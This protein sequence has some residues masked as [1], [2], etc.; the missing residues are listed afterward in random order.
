MLQ[1][2]GIVDQKESTHRSLSLQASVLAIFLCILF[3]A[4]AVAIKF[5]LTGLGTFTAAAVRF[6]ISVVAI[7][8]WAR[9]THQSIWFKKGQAHQILIISVLFVA[10]ISLFYVG[11]S[12]T[13]ASRGAL[14]V[15]LVPFLVLLLSHFFTRDDRITFG[16]LLGILMGFSGILFLFLQKRDLSGELRTGDMIIL[17]ATLL[18]ACSAV[19]IKKINQNYQPFQMVFYPLLLAVPFLYICA[20]VFDNPMMNSPGGDVVAAILYQGL[21]TGS[22]GFVAW[23]V[24]LQR[25]GAVSLHTFIFIMPVIGVLLGGLMLKEPIT[26]NVLIALALIG[27]GIFVTQFKKRRLRSMIDDPS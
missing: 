5:S 27:T 12:K 6:S 17:C 9:F 3:G 13:F 10:Q 25:Y 11:L 19:Y 2:Y 8:L 20:F 4:N 18:W 24:L 15:N 26:G 23:N 22:F 16:K 14:I 21:V 7:F 1:K